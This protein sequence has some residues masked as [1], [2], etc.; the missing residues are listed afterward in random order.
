M[1]IISIKKI[2]VLVLFCLFYDDAN[3]CSNDAIE[4]GFGPVTADIAK[5][6]FNSSCRFSSDL[7]RSE[8]GQSSSSHRERAPLTSAIS[9]LNFLPGIGSGV[10]FASLCEESVF[11]R[12]AVRRCPKKP[13]SFW[14]CTVCNLASFFTSIAERRGEH[15][16]IRF[17][18]N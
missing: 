9:A 14:C 5:T 8:D 3:I 17:K 15:G 7:L 10:D 6:S 13:L 18:E 1:R 16:L 2:L 12:N 11:V 4:S